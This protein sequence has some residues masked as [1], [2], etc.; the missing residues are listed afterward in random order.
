MK[1]STNPSATPSATEN[2]PPRLAPPGAGVPLI[3]LIFMRTWLG[4][5]VSKRTPRPASRALYEKLTQKTIGLAAKIAPE[6]RNKK[7][8][9]NPIL[10]LEDSSRYWSVNGVLEHL[11]IVSHGIEQAILSLSAGTVPPGAADTATVKPTDAKGDQLEAFTNYAPGLMARIDEKLAQPG[12]NIDSPLCF[13]H[14][15]FGPFQAKQWYWLLPSHTGIHYQQLKQI[16]AA[17]TASK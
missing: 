9:V 8:L 13:K 5:F 3:Q 7:I 14:P 15:W 10:G 2:T 6:L 16:V 17:L 4:P 1:S 12:M 11:L